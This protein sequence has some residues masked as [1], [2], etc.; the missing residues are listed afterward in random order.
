M[1]KKLLLLV[2]V[3]GI[4]GFSYYGEETQLTKYHADEIDGLDIANYSANPP[5]QKTGAPG[6]NNC[7]QC[8]AGSTQPAAG[9]VTYTFSGANN[10]YAP[11][12]SYTI[13]LSAGGVKNGFQMT[14]LD[15][16]DNAAGTFT[17][18]TNTATATAGGREYIHHTA[19]SG[20]TDFSFTW[21]APATDMG[22]LTV[23][24]AYNRSNNN[25][26]SSSDVIYLGQ[27]TISISSSASITKHEQLDQAFK[28]IPDMTSQQINVTYQTLEHA[29]I[30]LFVSD[31]TGKLLMKQSVG[32][33][34][35]GIYNETIELDRIPNSGIYLVSIFINNQVLT[36]K[37][38]I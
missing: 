32:N 29:S 16:S 36:R 26:A 9:T 30:E 18:G 3:I 4:I 14:I 38:M 28:V 10:E 8:H 12:Q 22:D 34:N 17:A 31:I 37:I 27:E 35:P 21:N 15:A 33:Q 25:G 13:D 19:S 24:Y 7:T 5:T 23:Y 6:E 2:P 11:G 20:V 1:N